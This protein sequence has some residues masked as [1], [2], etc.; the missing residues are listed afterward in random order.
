M[1]DI[2][3][4][5]ELLF[6]PS[7]NT[8]PPFTAQ[9]DLHL[10]VYSSSLSRLQHAVYLKHDVSTKMQELEAQPRQFLVLRKSLV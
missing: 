4:I 2:V 6:F 5:V 1:L 8:S 7:V 10:F 9:V 3:C